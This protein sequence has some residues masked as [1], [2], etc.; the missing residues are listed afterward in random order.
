MTRLNN[1]KTH[2]IFNDTRDYKCE[3]KL[4]KRVFI[5]NQ[6]P[7]KKNKNKNKNIARWLIH[8][9]RRKTKFIES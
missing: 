9:D 6:A 4:I 5:S 2:E 8:T 1:A 3:R 7:E